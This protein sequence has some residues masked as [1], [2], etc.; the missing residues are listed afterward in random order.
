[1]ERHPT[2]KSKTDPWSFYYYDAGARLYLGEQNR[3]VNAYVGLGVKHIL[4]RTDGRSDYFTPYVSIGF[5]LNA[6]GR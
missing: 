5:R 3:F 4:T 6:L 1:M 2:L